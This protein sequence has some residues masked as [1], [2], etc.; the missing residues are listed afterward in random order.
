MVIGH[1]HYRILPDRSAH[2][3]DLA[4]HGGRLFRIRRLGSSEVIETRNLWY[5]GVI[6]PKWREQMPDDAEFVTADSL[7][8]SLAEAT[9]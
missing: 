9:S 3:R 2:D 7:A 4:G 8:D 6:P 5:Q 1:T